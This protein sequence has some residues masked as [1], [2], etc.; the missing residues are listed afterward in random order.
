M[1]THK[2]IAASVLTVLVLGMTSGCAVPRHNQG[3]GAGTVFS[4]DTTAYA[5][6]A[7]VVLTLRNGNDHSLQYNLC[8]SQLYWQRDG[9]ESVSEDRVCTRE[10]RILGAGETATF[11]VE[12]P[13]TAR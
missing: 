3:E 7:E 13:S 4:T 5:P 11:T 8:S 2:I 10:L 12:L 9:W 6:G 1:Q